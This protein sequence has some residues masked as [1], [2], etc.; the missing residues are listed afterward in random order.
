MN[1]KYVYT[2]TSAIVQLHHHDELKVKKDLS[3]LLK[4][5]IVF[6]FYINK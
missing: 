5:M 2:K 4:I 6:D 3:S 1:I